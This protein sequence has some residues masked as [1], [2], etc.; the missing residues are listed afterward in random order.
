MEKNQPT[1]LIFN[2]YF[3]PGYKGGGP[4]ISVYNLSLLLQHDFRVKVFCRNRDGLTTIAY[5]NVKTNEWQLLEGSEVE[6]FYAGGDCIKL[7]NY[8]ALIEELEPDF[9]YLNSIFNFKFSILPLIAARLVGYDLSR[10]IVNPRGEVNE[11]ALEIKSAKKKVFLNLIRLSGVQNRVIWNPTN[12]QENERLLSVIGSQIDTRILS[13]IPRQDIPGWQRRSR[14]KRNRFV[15]LSR[16]DRIKNIEHFLSLLVGIDDEIV[17]DIYGPI[18]NEPYW[19]ECQSAIAVIS[20]TVT[21]E[22]KGEVTPSHVQD[23]LSRYDYFVLPSRGENFGHAI[24][25]GLSAGLP[26]LISDNTPWSSYKVSSFGFDIPLEDSDGWRI[27]LQKMINASEEQYISWSKNAHATAL[28]VARDPDYL[29]R[30]K[31]LFSYSD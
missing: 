23:V 8:K 24:M 28:S 4:I 31:E 22:Y 11:G 13:N 14:G 30:A 29:R 15:F 16:I 21:V 5:P 17:F 9:I 19:V 3:V 18:A 20:N 12:S 10:V 26:L 1:V 2:Q 25:D 7:A 6:V 27:A